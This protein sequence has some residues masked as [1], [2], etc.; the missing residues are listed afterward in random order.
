MNHAAVAKR[1]RA[2]SGNRRGRTLASPLRALA[3]G[4]GISKALTGVDGFDEI[5]YGGLPRGRPTLI[6]GSAGCGKTLFA[7]EFLVRGAL[8]FDEP[9]V[10]MSFE[11]TAEELAANVSSLGFDLDQMVAKRQLF[12]DHV[13]IERSEI[14]ET[15][16]YNLDGL[17]IRLQSAVD[18]V[19]AK[20][21]VLDT[22]EA[23]FGGFSNA[24]I[25]RAELRRLFRW[26]KDR[27]LTTV[28]TG[29]RG[30]GQLTRNGL[31]EYVSDCVI[32]LD[33][34]VVEQE[35]TR[36][37]RVVKYRGSF[38]GTNEYP[39]LI[40]EHGFSVLPLSA[41]RL[42]HRVSDEV[43]SIG[44]AAI[45]QMM[46]TGGVYRGSSILVSGTAGTGKSSLAA[47]FADAACRRGERCLI[48]A[49]EE[50]E[51][52]IVRNMRSIG[53]DLRKWID[54]GLLRIHA[55]RPTSQGLELHLVTVHKLVRDFRPS[56]LVMDPISNLVA[57]GSVSEAKAMF[58]RVI[59]F[60]K[61]SGVTALYTS[62][63]SPEGAL[64]KT[65]IGISSLID[66]WM[67]LRQTELNG[68]RN[69]ILFLLKSRGMN[70]SNQVREFL[71][72]EHGIEVRDAYL[73]PQGVLT[74]SAR[75]AQ[76][77]RDREEE[78]RQS[79]ENQQ[80]V[81]QLESRRKTLEAQAEALKEELGAV[82]KNVSRIASEEERRQKRVVDDR[83][84][85]ARS[86]RVN[87]AL[88]SDEKRNLS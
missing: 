8:E 32:L 69:R 56:A 3:T 58:V 11:E 12:I 28:I 1:R 33:H 45:D 51:S 86:R 48:L 75:L 66:T 82:A 73:G 23:L 15:G 26:L 16:D 47:S 78:L 36:R 19:G 4:R 35:S 81:S 72:S 21:V 83:K 37:L 60:L 77:A 63:T 87:G 54:K 84:A 53:I 64:E 14:E 50:S 62:L 42:D 85:M 41:L 38:H 7:T 76:E 46:S 71:L 17:F 57:V 6:C 25:L 59:D 40:D 13:H 43:V 31:E 10:F 39:F 27:G 2:A 74:G 52:Q 80:R 22:P 68:E 67:L 34:R 65:E 49:Y 44:V 30:E 20:R 29:E 24:A 55:S 18:Q 88:R 61:S 70:H 9:G 5:T 79:E